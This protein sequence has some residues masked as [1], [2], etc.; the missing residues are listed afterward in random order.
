MAGVAFFF[1]FLSSVGLG[2]DDGVAVFVESQVRVLARRLG[3]LDRLSPSS[4]DAELGPS[5]PDE[6]DDTD[7]RTMRDQRS[8][9]AIEKG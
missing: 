1:F 2:G 9:R 8:L 3:G 5:P 7:F 4:F 6:A